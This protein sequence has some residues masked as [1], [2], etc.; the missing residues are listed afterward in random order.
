MVDFRAMLRH[1]VVSNYALIDQLEFE[2]HEGLN[3]LSGET[4]SGKSIIVDALGLLLGSKASPEMVRT[5]CDR[6]SVTGVFYIGQTAL[7]QPFLEEQG[8]TPEE[9]ELIVKRE[10]F[11]EGKSRAFINQQP[12]TAATLK[13][14]SRWLVDIHGQNEQQALT[15][16]DAQ[17]AMLDEF[18]DNS[19]LLED[20]AALSSQ[21]AVV[22]AKKETLERSE[23]EQNR[24]M[25]LLAFQ[26]KEIEAAHLAPN[27][28]AVLN[29]EHKLLAN[30]TK[31]FE[32]ANEV[33]ATLYESEGSAAQSV[34]LAER[35]LE[36]IARID[37]QLAE[38]LE[39]LRTA[40]IQ[41]EEVAFSFRS[42]LKTI[43]V[44]PQRLE[45]VESR[46]AEIEKLRRKYGSTVNDI[47]KFHVEISEQLHAFENREGELQALTN[48]MNILRESYRAKA[49]ALS[50]R[51][52]RAGG[53]LERALEQ[54]LKELAME[55]TRFKVSLAAAPTEFSASGLDTVE[56][57]V[58]PNLGEDLKPL[59]KIASGGELSRLMLALK[60]ITH[61]DVKIKTLVFDE[62]DAGIGG[63]TAEVLG[64]K[65]KSLSQKNQI[66]CVTH[67]PQIASFANHH[68][69]IEKIEEKGRTVTRVAHLDE[70]NRINEL[71]RML[72]GA[73]I[74]DAV[75]KHARELLKQSSG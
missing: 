5:G 68:F 18:A 19:A 59:A 71:A 48:R 40:R 28:D 26:K 45:Q 37:E 31:L 22:R 41:I 38:N 3:L 4:G 12:V 75:K 52:K 29:A 55:R 21:W 35:A 44:S 24:L 10:V 72:S 74:T 6:A 58:A 25:D 9:G 7:M 8:V 23:K 73:K 67:L 17:L 36:S 2:L 51:R 49:T 42:Y 32:A 60:T 47:L 61:A 57:L 30:A 43:D 56:Y 11:R 16:T 39:Q 1:L 62:V 70:E 50:E 34:S 65:L 64:R 53:R 13:S 54:E 46:I 66:L 33:Y 69:F 15:E 27:E 63:R 14:L 20:L